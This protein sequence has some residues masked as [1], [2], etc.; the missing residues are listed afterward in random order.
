MQTINSGLTA[1]EVRDFCVAHAMQ[2]G[3]EIE[4][5]QRPEKVLPSKIA[6]FLAR[7]IMGD[8]NQRRAQA[9]R[10]ARDRQSVAS[11]LSA[12]AAAINGK[13]EEEIERTKR[14]LAAKLS[15]GA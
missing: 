4:N 10:E 6:N 3:L 8:V 15:G 13:P 9:A 5:G 12:G 11:R 1:T 14:I 7:S 2:W